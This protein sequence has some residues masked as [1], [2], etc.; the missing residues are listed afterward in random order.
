MSPTRQSPNLNSDPTGIEE[1][2]SLAASF[3]QSFTWR[4]M[5]DTLRI[6]GQCLAIS[7]TLVSSL[8][9]QQPA[10][11]LLK[12]FETYQSL[13]Q[14][15]KYGL[16]WISV[17]PLVN[18]ARV[19]AVQLVPQKPGTMYVAFG[20]GNLWKSTNNG[21]SWEPKF[22]EQAS[23][24]IGDFALA[25]SDPDIIY[26]GTGESLKK[27]RNFTIPGTGI[28][29]SDDGGENWR[30]LGL[31]DSW[32]IGEIAVHPQN[33]D[34]AVVAVLGHFWSTNANRGLFR[35]DDGGN[36][37]QHVLKISESVGANDIVWAS[38][39]PNILYASTWHNH[40]DVSGTE[41]GI[42]RSKDAGLTWTK[43]AGGLPRGAN[44]GR[45]GLAVSSTNSQKIYALIDQRDRIEK[46]AAANIYRSEDGGEHWTRT[47][48]D[49]LPI[50]S[51]IG[52]YF[53]DI[54]VNPMNDE[55][56]FALGVRLAHSTNGGKSFEL[57]GGKVSH[58]TPSAASGLHLDHCEMWINPLNPNHIVLGNDGGLYQSYDKGRS[59]LH[60]NN[61][62]TGEFYDIEV[63]RNLP[64]TIFAGAQDD[65]TVYGPAQELDES[66]TNVW[67]YLWID[68]WNGGDGCITKVDPND[69]NTVYFSAQEGAFRRKNLSNDSSVSIRARLPEAIE[70]RLNFNFVAP[71][72]ISPHDS[73][74]LFLAGNY[75]F[76]S[77]DRGDNWHVISGN[78]ANSS[79]PNRESVA[80]S[81]IVESSRVRGL[82]YVGTDKGALWVTEDGGMTWKERSNQLPVGYIRSICPSRFENSRVYVSVSGI[83]YD[84]LGSHI[85]CSE[86]RGKSWRSIS[87]NL[88]EEP[89]NIITEDPFFENILYVGTFRGIYVST[90]R[91]ASWSL[92]GRDLPTCSVA[93]IVVHE[94]SRDIIIGTH[95]RGVY[96][97]SL[98]EFYELNSKQIDREEESYLFP[99]PSA[100]HPPLGDT[101]VGLNFRP[102]EK[103]TFSY[104]LPK[105]GLVQ[106]SIKD[107]SNE[108]LAVISTTGKRGFNQLR[109]DLVVETN[110]SLDPY[111]TQYKKYLPPGTY[112][113]QMSTN[114]SVVTER[115]LTV[116][117]SK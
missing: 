101:R 102:F 82:M 10:S 44:V 89:A 97:S 74:T 9:A 62:P 7:C 14:E 2:Q 3:T 99:I 117:S 25:P 5:L 93:D 111:F 84:D 103:C 106:F 58:L 45:I 55:E 6:I 91:G 46:Q 105:D 112:S 38:D 51:R 57:I 53:A 39:D 110:E 69:S 24:G 77:T 94:Q 48:E 41:S 30:H 47:H 108:E 92:L 36:T 86:D 64:Y 43:C 79:D 18:S 20:S 21:L 75:V 116:R 66:R 104:W 67:K 26:V 60:H 19:E 78:I 80:A 61:L 76:K 35:T 49:K 8:A 59:W 68:P 98:I 40:P 90:D 95:G 71:F 34:C 4:N 70:D 63:S 100:L 12:S 13:K 16:K 29:R 22:N 54:Y 23:H 11:P 87:N 56:V 81:E 33:P 17:G 115:N 27:A 114:S 83:N 73:N 28:Y 15:T 107:K 85:F 72:M 50:F 88:P 1:L 65:A 37:W 109:W 113:V 31:E 96:R 52:W 42:Y 32:H